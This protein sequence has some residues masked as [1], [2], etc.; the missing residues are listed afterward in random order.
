[1]HASHI[2]HLENVENMYII[3][4]LY[5][6]KLQIRIK[7]YFNGRIFVVGTAITT[8]DMGEMFQYDLIFILQ[9][10]C[11]CILDAFFFFLSSSFFSYSATAIIKFILKKIW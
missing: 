4:F 2:L 10:K 9:M 5:H 11:K 6:F 3:N 8:S 7:L 1:M